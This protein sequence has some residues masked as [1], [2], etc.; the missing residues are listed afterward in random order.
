MDPCPRSGV[1][2]APVNGGRPHSVTVDVGIAHLLK[3]RQLF[4]AQD[5]VLTVCHLGEHALNR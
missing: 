3:N 4:F 1:D 5:E 2:S